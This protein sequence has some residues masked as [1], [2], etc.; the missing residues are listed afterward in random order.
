MKNPVVLILAS[1]LLVFAVPFLFSSGSVEMETESETSASVTVTD[2]F[3]REVEIPGRIERIA[4]IYAF[5]VHVVTMLDRGEDIVSVVYGSKRDR[6][7]NEINPFIKEAATPSDDGVINIEELLKTNPDIIFLKGDT[8]QMPAEIEK[9]ERF[10]LP[11]VVIEY[12]TIEEQMKAI[13]LIG[14][15]IGKKEKAQAY[16]NYYQRQIDFVESRVIDI[17]TE[18]RIRVYHSVNEAVRTDA[19]GTLPAEWTELTGAINVSVGEPL[20]FHDNKYFAS[21]EQIYLWDAD[22]II[23]NQEDVDE[24]ILTNEKWAGLK[25]V[26]NNRV[27]QIPIGISRWGH[28]GGMETPLALVWTAKLLYPDRFRD[29]N[30]EQITRSFYTTFFNHTISDEMLERILSADKMRLPKGEI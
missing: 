15:V 5:T 1:A 6:L 12:N 16:N 11:Y 18:D 28:P 26:Q 2:C 9:I 22:V 17:P 25:A 30:I 23:A 14:T 10:N 21:L 29:V 27:Y 19:P 3:G 7:L 20:R 4:C 8:A 13:E 24:Y